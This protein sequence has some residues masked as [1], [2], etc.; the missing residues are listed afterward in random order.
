MNFY[1]QRVIEMR[2]HGHNIPDVQDTTEISKPFVQKDGS[3]IQPKGTENLFHEIAENT[4]NLRR[5]MDSH[6]SLQCP[7]EIPRVPNGTLKAPRN[8]FLV[9]NK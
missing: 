5:Y 2:D 1:I 9:I 3:E 7:S 4:S 8:K 6:F